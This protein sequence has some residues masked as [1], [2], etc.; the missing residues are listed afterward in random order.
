[1]ASHSRC[2]VTNPELEGATNCPSSF[3]HN[4]SARD[5]FA[6]ASASMDQSLIPDTFGFSLYQDPPKKSLPDD[7]FKEL[8]ADLGEVT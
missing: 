1:M 6:I 7:R 2:G 4:Q 5:I 3:N 8:S